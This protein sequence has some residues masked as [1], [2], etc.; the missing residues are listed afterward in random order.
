MLSRWNTVRSSF[1]S[2]LMANPAQPEPAG[3]A[4]AAAPLD[5]KSVLQQMIARDG[6][7][8]HLKVGRP[9][10]FRV[11]GELEPMDHPALRPWDLKGLAEQLMTPRKIKQFAD[12]KECDFAIGVPGIGRFGVNLYQQR[13]SLS[14]AMP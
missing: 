14:Y 12:E 1:G 5:F 13:V 9:P 2:R 3:A 6:S 11:N 8:L 10:T 7:D 4:A